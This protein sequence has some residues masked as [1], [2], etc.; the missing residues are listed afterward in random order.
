M[1]WTTWNK[2]NEYPP[3]RIQ[4]SIAEIIVDLLLCLLIAFLIISF[5]TSLS[6]SFVDFKL[7]EFIWIDVDL[8]FKFLWLD[9]FKSRKWS[10]KD[11]SA[12]LSRDRVSDLIEKSEK[13]VDTFVNIC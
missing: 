11:L 13:Q 1:F 7:V 4:P 3:I 10:I 9:H 2:P 12:W 5:T 8:M 6:I